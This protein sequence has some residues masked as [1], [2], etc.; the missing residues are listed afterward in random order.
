MKNKNVL[1]YSYTYP[2]ESKRLIHTNGFIKIGNNTQNKAK[3]KLKTVFHN[4][5][6]QPYLCIY[7]NMNFYF[8]PKSNL[9]T[10]S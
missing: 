7:T 8:Y 2:S 1:L 10:A 9:K 3:T 6:L 4:F 5:P